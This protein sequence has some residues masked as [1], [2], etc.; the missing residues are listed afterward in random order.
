[1]R[2]YIYHII[3]TGGYRGGGYPPFPKITIQGDTGIAYCGKGETDMTLLV[4]KKEC[5][6]HAKIRAMILMA[7]PNWS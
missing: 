7:H 4:V 5:I 6:A 3:Y 2:P 1:M